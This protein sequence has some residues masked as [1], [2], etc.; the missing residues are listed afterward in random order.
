MCQYHTVLMT[1]AL[2]YRLKSGRVIPPVHSS[3]SRLL[4]LFEVF[5]IYT[6]CEIIC[7]SSVKNTVGSLIEIASW[8]V[9]SYRFYVKHIE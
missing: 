4:L 2:K 8:S 3:F 1:V 5:C 6:K 9:L 7:S